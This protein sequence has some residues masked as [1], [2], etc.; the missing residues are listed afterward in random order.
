MAELLN[1]TLLAIKGVSALISIY[2][3]NGHQVLPQGF[4]CACVGTIRISPIQPGG[5]MLRGTW[6]LN[7]SLPTCITREEDPLAHIGPVR[8]PYGGAGGAGGA[9]RGGGTGAAG[10]TGGGG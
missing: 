2:V 6:E 1:G 7:P 9:G 5:W 8:D 4:P 10:G 3:A